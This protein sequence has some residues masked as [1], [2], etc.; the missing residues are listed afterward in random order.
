MGFG[1]HLDDIDSKMT[2]R[3][4]NNDKENE[5]EFEGDGDSNHMK[6]SQEEGSTEVVAGPPGLAGL[7]ANL[8]GVIYSK[9]QFDLGFCNN[10]MH[11]FVCCRVKKV[12]MLVLL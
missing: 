8:S 10:M 7:I 4:D 11:S 2:K 5:I 12:L 3:R 9:F 6:E 1:V